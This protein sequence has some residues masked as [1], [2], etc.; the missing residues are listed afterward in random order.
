ME[1]TAATSSVTT[2]PR[3]LGFRL[4]P[5]ALGAWT[6]A[7]A[8]VAYLA[9]RDGGYDTIVRSEVGIAVWWIVLLAALAGILPARIGLAGWVTIGLLGAFALWTGLAIGWSQSAETSVIELGREAAYLGFLVLAIAL[10]GRAAARHTI[11][12]LACAIGLVTVLAVLS[13]VHPQWFPTNVQFRFLGAAS[14]RRLSY[15][16][17]YWNALAA[18]VAMGVPLLMALA[19]G[20]RTIVARAVSAAVLPISALCIYLTISRGG[21]IELG[22]AVLVFMLFVPR[23][24]EALAT[25]LVTGAGAA[26]LIWAAS[27]RAPVRSGLDTVAA[28]HGG[29]VLLVLALVVCVG[30][31]LLQVSLALAARHFEV[32]RRLRTGRGATAALAAALAAVAAVAAIAAGVPGKVERQWHNFK[33][34]P[35]VVA[36]VSESTVFSRLSAINGNGRYQYW[37]AASHANQTSPWRGI[38]PGTF[39]FWWAAHATT[40]G[41]VRNAHS[42]YFETLAETG[43]IGLALVVGLLVWMMG[44]AVWRL[45]HATG[46]MRLWLAAAAAGLAV[47][48][49][50]AAV[51]WVWQMAAIVAAALLLGAVIV[52]GRERPQPLERPDL[53]HRIHRGLLVAIALIAL[54]AISLPLAGAIAI[55]RSQVAAAGGQLAAAYTDSLAAQRLQPYAATPRLQ[56]ALVL[57]AAGE[58]GPAASAAQAATRDEPTN[59]QTWL[60]LARIDAEAGAYRAGIAA[61]ERARTLNPRSQLFLSH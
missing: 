56:E 55:R 39:Q 46:S 59:W 31:A 45:S 24:L 42:L 9:L 48:M 3:R 10:Q 30:V 22:V 8:L 12:G 32:P 61:L 40:D 27:R 36:P 5:P 14:V 28:T 23:R 18:F 52:A 38:G 4:D 19:L 7:F 34:P 21:V 47:F 15:P 58:F 6:L 2:V 54:G 44:V 41:P 53:R 29:A 1:L 51:E 25:L 50:A 17:N 26:I 43:L 35:G 20:A 11:N 16:L 37:V 33:Q 49:A 57:E 13:R 60:T